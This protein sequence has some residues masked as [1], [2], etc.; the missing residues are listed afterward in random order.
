MVTRIEHIHNTHTHT[1]RDTTE[2]AISHDTH[3]PQEGLKASE[4]M[5]VP[6]RHWMQKLG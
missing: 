3:K 4:V 5:G 1:Q 6:G 2:T